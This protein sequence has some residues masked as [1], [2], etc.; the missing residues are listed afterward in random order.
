M[1]PLPPPI[2]TGSTPLDAEQTLKA[3]RVAGAKNERGYLLVSAAEGVD[4]SATTTDGLRSVDTGSVPVRETDALHAY[5]IR[6]PDWKL[7][8][9]VKRKPARVRSLGYD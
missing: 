4:V 3:P 8:L 1:G 7:G 2:E 6:E 9:A 5:R